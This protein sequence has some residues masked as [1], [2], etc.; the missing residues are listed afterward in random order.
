MNDLTGR[1]HGL[2]VI[3]LTASLVACSA[4]PGTQKTPG[5]GNSNSSGAN[6]QTASLS[7]ESGDLG[8]G[9]APTVTSGASTTGAESPAGSVGAGAGSTSATSTSSGTSA[10]AITSSSG[11]SISPDA[12]TDA[13]GSAPARAADSGPAEGGIT[14]P[15]ITGPVKILVLGSSNE[16]GSCW[17]AFLQ[18]KL[19]NAG[20]T[21]FQFVGSVMSAP[22][23]P[24]V[25]MYQ[26]ALTAHDGWVIENLSAA[27]WLAIFK[28]N[29]PDIVLE[30]NGG[31][32]LLDGHPYAN[33]I[34]AYTLGVQAARMVNPL[35]IYLAAQHTPQA[36]DNADVMALDAAMVPWAAGI[37]TA[38]SPVE[39]VDLF[40][41]INTQTDTS[42][43][44]HLNNAGSEIVAERWFN[45]LLPI[46]QP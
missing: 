32:D 25:S 8:N 5:A 21:N 24:G 20:I 30:H 35:V 31:A 15:P 33:I 46:L 12:S 26:A 42:D 19:R 4:Q 9:E 44:V 16:L 14:L 10:G 34:K 18:L 11:Q 7:G 22:G 38:T 23:C 28:A 2:W 43:G 13:G 1:R 6:G 39:L 29:P 45:A 41:G 40:T 37:T 3:A 36:P 17:R 27:D